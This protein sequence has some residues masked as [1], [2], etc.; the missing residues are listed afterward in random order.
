TFITNPA[1]WNV[2]FVGDSLGQPSNG[3]ANYDALQFSTSNG[4]GS[5][6]TYSN[7]G[8]G[9]VSPTP[10]TFTN[11]NVVANGATLQKINETAVTEPVNLFNVDSSIPTAFQVNSGSYAAPTSNLQNLEYNLDPYT[12]SATSAVDAPGIANV[13]AGPSGGLVFQL[14]NNGVN[15]NYVTSS[16][17]LTVY[18]T[19]YRTVGSTSTTTYSVSFNG[20]NTQTLQGD[21]LTN[22]TNIQLGMALPNPGVTV[23]VYETPNTAASITTGVGGNDVLLGTLSYSTTPTLLYKVPQYNYY[24]AP[25]VDTATYTGEQNN[26]NFVLAPAGT[27]PGNTVSRGQ[28]FT[29]TMPE[30]TT[31]SSTTPNANVIIGIT[32]SSSVTSTPLYWLNA[33]NGNNNAVEYE[34]TQNIQT[35]AVQGFRTERGGEIGS[36]GTT[37]LT[38]YE[39]KSVD[40]LKFFVGPA[41]SNTVNTSTTKLVGPLTVGDYIGIVPN[42]TI[43]KVNA[44]CS[45]STTSCNVT[46]LKNLTAVPS[47]TSA[48]VGSPLNTASTPIAVLDSNANNSTNLIVIG[49]G[50]VNTVAQ[51]I[52]NAQP[53]LQS[54]FGPNSTIVQAYGNKIL[55]AGYTAQQTVTAG[56]NFINQLLQDASS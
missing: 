11:A 6:W 24:I 34:S 18:V 46:G 56:N 51:S 7:G 36:I 25:T 32:N 40:G 41:T 4:G 23:N 54:S 3:N 42:V 19:G 45:F 12:F 21:Y 9:L 16:N 14:V 48:V 8:K 50:Y 37:S 15:G 53:S 52:F 22:A 49:S 35:K 33:T 10:Y 39:P 1:I 2:N 13:I 47:A 26:V 44:T 20:F 30:I 55:V 28:Y 5:A 43:G 29:Y 38:Y 27:V 31:P 17:P